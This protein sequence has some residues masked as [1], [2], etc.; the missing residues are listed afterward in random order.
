MLGM[1]EDGVVGVLEEGVS[2]GQSQFWLQQDSP[3]LPEPGIYV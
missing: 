3:D 2:L 1:T